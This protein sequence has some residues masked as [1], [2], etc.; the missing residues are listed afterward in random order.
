M[1]N[2]QVTKQAFRVWEYLKRKYN[3]TYLDLSVIQELNK[4]GVR[5]VL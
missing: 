5:V 1:T 3:N 4:R 2:K